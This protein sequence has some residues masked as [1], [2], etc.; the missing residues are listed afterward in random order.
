MYR[1]KTIY[2]HVGNNDLRQNK[3]RNL[4][5]SNQNMSYWHDKTMCKCHICKSCFEHFK[6]QLGVSNVVTSNRYAQFKSANH[7]EISS[8]DTLNNK[9][10]YSNPAEKRNQ[11]SG[12]CRKY[13]YKNDHKI[14]AKRNHDILVKNSDIKIDPNTNRKKKIVVIIS[15][16]K[17]NCIGSVSSTVS[18]I[19]NVPSVSNV[20]SDIETDYL[21][22]DK[23]ITHVASDI[24]ICNNQSSSEEFISTPTIP[25]I[26]ILSP[27]TESPS[28]N[29]SPKD[30]SERLNCLRTDFE[31]QN[32]YNADDT[33]C[34]GLSFDHFKSKKSH[35]SRRN[36]IRDVKKLTFRSDLEREL[37][38]LL[39]YINNQTELSN[40]DSA[41]EN[42]L[43]KTLSFSNRF[44]INVRDSYSSRNRVDPV[45]AFYRR[46]NRK[47]S[48]Q[49]S[50]SNPT[51]ISNSTSNS[52]SNSNGHNDCVQKAIR[53][54]NANSEC[55]QINHVCGKYPR[56]AYEQI[57]NQQ[58]NVRCSATGVELSEHY[59]KIWNVHPPLSSNIVFESNDPYSLMISITDIEVERVISSLPPWSA[60]GVD[61]IFFNV[62]KFISKA[63]GGMDS[64]LKIFNS[65]ITNKYIPSVLRNSKTILV[66][67]SK[68]SQ[69]SKIDDFRPISISSTLYRI[70][71][72]ILANRIQTISSRIYCEAQRGFLGV[73][74]CFNN[75]I[76]Y[77]CFVKKVK[78]SKNSQGLALFVDLKKAFDLLDHNCL[79]SE[80][81]KAFGGSFGQLIASIY[82]DSHTSFNADSDPHSIKL[83]NGVRQ[84]CPLSPLL[85]NICIDSLLRKLETEEGLTVSTCLGDC[86][87]TVLAYADDLLIL[88][89]NAISL[90]KYIS[91]TN[92][93]CQVFGMAINPIKCGLILIG[94]WD[95]AV[96]ITVNGVSVPVVDD[97]SAYR[98]L[99][100]KLST[101]YRIF[102]EDIIQLI[103]QCLSEME[104][105]NNSK[106]YPQN[107][108]KIMNWFILS[109]LEHTLRLGDVKKDI[110]RTFCGSV[111]DYARKFFDLPATT[112]EY[113]LMTAR[114]N[115]GL[116]LFDLHLESSFRSVLSIIN[117]LNSNCNNLSILTAEHL[118][119]SRRRVADLKQ[120]NREVIVSLL[121]S[122]SNN[123]KYSGMS[124]HFNCL[125]SLNVKFT[126]KDNQFFLVFPKIA[127]IPEII[128]NSL[129]SVRRFISNLHLESWKKQVQGRT[130]ICFSS[131]LAAN[132]FLS[133]NS[134][135]KPSTLT[136]TLLARLDLLPTNSSVKTRK[137]NIKTAKCRKC[138]LVEETVAHILNGCHVTQPDQTSRHN[139]I[140]K[141][142]LSI[143]RLEKD[144]I[145]RIDKVY[146]G[147]ALR[148]D[149]IIIRKATKTDIII[150][151]TVAF[152]SQDNLNKAYQHKIDKYCALKSLCQQKGHSLIILPFVIG[153]LGTCPA[154][155]TKVFNIL[156]VA[157][158][159]ILYHQCRMVE[160]VLEFGKLMYHKFMS[161]KTVE[162]QMPVESLRES[163]TQQLALDNGSGASD[164]ITDHDNSSTDEEFYSAD[165]YFHQSAPQQSDPSKELHGS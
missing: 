42:I 56:R 47:L 78:N 126:L 38:D 31:Q 18:K 149:I 7:P 76:E 129:S 152:D 91:L 150:D 163:N 71:A 83:C 103:E 109:R 59:S 62:W 9:I 89:K 58:S 48:H 33:V 77:N 116:G 88:A 40:L 147:S 124:T 51:T 139:A 141:K 16:L 143:A 165:E 22:I 17:Q 54:K 95:H 87:R 19:S 156:Q 72:S 148:P 20:I 1:G 138:N 69:P 36:L 74:G 117:S 158:T 107:K 105:V 3:K 84:G 122:P 67:K 110:L 66:A 81:V 96:K 32:S 43:K 98:Y 79:I 135:L 128:C 93:W 127:N 55:Y 140:V 108:L 6:T 82:V 34:K 100:I 75:I 8:V 52:N 161:I 60:C 162:E 121:N 101:N 64:L 92:E 29:T 28:S 50:N 114:L 86:K 137:I 119:R 63:N 113:F 94:K 102:K 41:C 111:R 57:I 134:S 136:F 115:G 65:W 99:G 21:N 11:R 49:T 142:L 85:F 144:D 118:A 125:S 12:Y 39:K 10:Q 70:F 26:A 4:S 14:N 53:Y 97:T 5:N 153:S 73:D 159:D 13:Y 145:L 154:N 120:F 46:K 157:P 24:K 146:D 68:S 106:L 132:K 30:P 133:L 15:D 155:Q 2:H 35:K 160:S 37:S 23:P 90:D 123:Y 164:F 131:S 80:S 151:V 130:A 112:S 44:D 45:S 104:M 61:G 25:K 27:T